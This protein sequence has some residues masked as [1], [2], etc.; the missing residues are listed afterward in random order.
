MRTIFTKLDGTTPEPD[1]KEM[2]ENLKAHCAI[3]RKNSQDRCD[4]EKELLVKGCDKNRLRKSLNLI[5]GLLTRI[6][7]KEKI[8]NNPNSTQKQKD[9]AA[10]SI[11]QANISIGLADI[12]NKIRGEVEAIGNLDKTRKDLERTQQD[13]IDAIDDKFECAEPPIFKVSVKCKNQKMRN[14]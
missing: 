2:V 11:D 7:N 13:M 12:P 14:P 5:K 9:D 10:N 8:I 4:L 3:M 6:A 1:C